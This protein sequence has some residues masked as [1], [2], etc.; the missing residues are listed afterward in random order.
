M[1]DILV[2]EWIKQKQ[3]QD[4]LREAMREAA[5]QKQRADSLK[6]KMDKPDFCHQLLET[7]ELN[8]AALPKINFKGNV[9]AEPQFS[10]ETS[11]EVSVFDPK[12]F[13]R[14]TSARITCRDMDIEC[15]VVNC[16]VTHYHLCVHEEAVKALPDIGE[17]R[18]PLTAKALAERIVKQMVVYLSPDFM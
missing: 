3:I 14:Q 9:K 13:E 11:W 5:A 1:N 17:C 8:V 18:M 7:L 2:P 16:G 10:D 4:S 12:V 15:C 6:I